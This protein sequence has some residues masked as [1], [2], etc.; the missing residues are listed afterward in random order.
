MPII[1]ASIPDEIITALERLSAGYA[2]R[3]ELIREAL[4][5][6]ISEKRWLAD[7]KG[8][9]TTIVLTAYDKS[10][11]KAEDLMRVEHEFDDI[12][13]VNTHIHMDGDNCFEIFVVRGSGN[14]IKELASKLSA[15]KGI[16]QVRLTAGL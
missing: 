11:M 7:P 5:N 12:I 1:S 4:R 9:F 16:R 15:V 8:M 13:A 6:Y 14:K 3:S 2:T 10:K